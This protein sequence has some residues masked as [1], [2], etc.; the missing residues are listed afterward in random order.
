MSALVTEADKQ[1]HAENMNNLARLQAERMAKAAA[2]RLKKIQNIAKGIAKVQLGSLPAEAA[3]KAAAMEA[4]GVLAVMLHVVLGQAPADPR[5]MLKVFRPFLPEV[6]KAVEGGAN[7]GVL[8]E[9][10]AAWLMHDR[11]R[12]EAL[13]PAL[14]KVFVHMYDQAIIE[15]DHSKDWFAAHCAQVEALDAAATTAR[16]EN[17]RA[18][19]EADAA[20]AKSVAAVET[21][22]QAAIDERAAKKS[23]ENSKC[24][25]GA[26]AEEEA[27]EKHNAGIHRTAIKANEQATS[28]AAANKKSSDVLHQDKLKAIAASEVADKALGDA[29]A[30]KTAL[31]P[32]ITWLDTAEEK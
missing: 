26:T 32:Y 27:R 21:Q 3:S 30:L 5:G 15:E 11:A 29:A 6:K 7:P 28:R 17:E 16:A 20:A 10:L 1:W 24:G 4:D 25:G 22:K 18:S 23:A 8:H 14:P 13:A 12:L 19:T 2:D 31:Q 9:S